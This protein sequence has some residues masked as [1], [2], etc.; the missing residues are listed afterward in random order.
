MEGTLDDFDLRYVFRFLS[1]ARKTGRLVVGGPAG[2]GRVFFRAGEIYHAESDGRREGFGRKLVNAGR[3]TEQQLRSTLEYCAT[4]GKGL[5]EALVDQG[6]VERADLESVLCEEIQEVALGLFR[7]SSGRFSFA[8][9]EEV[10]SD[11]LILVPV[12]GLLEED[13]EVGKL[14]VPTL[15]SPSGGVEGPDPSISLSPEEWTVVAA[16]DGRRTVG[17]IALLVRKSDFS[18]LRHLRRLRSL[19]LIDMQ[20]EAQATG[21]GGD[22]PGTPRSPLGYPP[23]PPPARRRSGHPPP[24]PPSTTIDLRAPSEVWMPQEKRPSPT[25]DLSATRET[26]P[27]DLPR[28][29][30]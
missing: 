8:T 1:S 10:E 11:T 30:S 17:E 26:L 16:V 5:G 23:P 19:G 6:L 9:D 4:A 12:E 29:P 7:N 3:I 14:A 13:S 15:R 28:G 2:G 18:V 24:P 25:V 21:D 27:R 20:G 22:Y